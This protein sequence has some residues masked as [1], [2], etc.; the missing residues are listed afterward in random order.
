MKWTATSRSAWLLTLI[1][2]TPRFVPKSR[3][4]LPKQQLLQG[5]SRLLLS[6]HGKF[7]NY[8]ITCLPEIMKLISLECFY[9]FTMKRY[10]QNYVPLKSC[11]G[12]KQKQHY[13]QID[14]NQRKPTISLAVFV[15]L[16]L[17]VL[18]FGSCPSKLL[19]LWN[20]SNGK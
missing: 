17:L 16:G 4:Q 15:L 10:L 9:C 13:I 3:S 8:K 18:R 7:W 11:S 20:Q 1:K 19:A 12:I 6:R 2:A 14:S 5:Y